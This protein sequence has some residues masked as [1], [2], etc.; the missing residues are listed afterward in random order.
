MVQRRCDALSIELYISRHAQALRPCV[1]PRPHRAGIRRAAPARHAAED[2]GVPPWPAAELRA[3]R[4]DLPLGARGA[5]LAARTLHRGRD[6]CRGGALDPW[7]AAA[8]PR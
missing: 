5:A 7:R 3:R 6:A 4:T 2:P 1:G 8:P